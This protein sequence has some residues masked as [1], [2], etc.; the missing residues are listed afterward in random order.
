M[1]IFIII[2]QIIKTEICCC[3]KLYLYWGEKIYL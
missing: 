1:Q 3:W 2:M